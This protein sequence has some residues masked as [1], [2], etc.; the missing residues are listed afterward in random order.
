MTPELFAKR[1]SSIGVIVTDNADKMVRRVV[2]VVDQIVV[3]GT[4][5]DTGHAR[6]NWHI[7]LGAAVTEETDTFDKIGSE[8]LSKHQSVIASR[9]AGQDV[10]NSNNV[11]YI[12]MLNRGH[13]SQA[14]AMFVEQAVLE[15]IR[16]AKNSRLLVK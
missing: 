10:Y 13:S 16:A 4:P 11:P 3:L 5:V 6:S 12:G 2:T 9:R 14:P 1:M 8:T 7:G 15:G